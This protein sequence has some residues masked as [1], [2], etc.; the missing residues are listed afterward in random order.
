MLPFHQI[1]FFFSVLLVKYLSIRFSHKI[2][3]FVFV[4]CMFVY[5]HPIVPNLVI[6]G[7]HV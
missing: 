7:N 4:W 1:I 5:M 6:W 3:E 2:Y